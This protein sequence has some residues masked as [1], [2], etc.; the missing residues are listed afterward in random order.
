MFDHNPNSVVANGIDYQ[1]T[2]HFGAVLF[3]DRSEPVLEFKIGKP[4]CIAISSAKGKVGDLE[5]EN[6]QWTMYESPIRTRTPLGTSSSV[7]AIRLAAEMLL[8]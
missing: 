6:E 7:T 8:S 1:M 2:T 3:H 4:A 5:F